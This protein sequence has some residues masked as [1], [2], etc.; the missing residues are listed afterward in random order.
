MLRRDWTAERRFHRC[1]CMCVCHAKILVCAPDGP[2]LMLMDGSAWDSAHDA[3]Q[4]GTNCD[5]VFS[6]RNS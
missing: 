1:V 6:L 3:A 5:A 2:V 4:Q